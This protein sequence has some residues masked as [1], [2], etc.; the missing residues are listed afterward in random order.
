MHAWR[1][2]S[3]SVLCALC[4][5]AGAGAGDDKA[6]T[7]L[8]KLLARLEDARGNSESLRQE[9]LALRREFPGTTQAV[10]AAAALA[11]LTSPPDKLDA[12]KIPALERF[13]WQPKELVAVLHEHRGRHGAGVNAVAVSPDGKRVVSG[14]DNSLVRIWDAA[15]MRLQEVLGVS[16]VVYSTAFT[17]DGKTLAVGCADGNIQFWDVGTTPARRLSALNTSS[18]GVHSLAFTADGKKL[19]LGSGDGHIHIWEGPW[20][21]PPTEPFSSYIG[22]TQPVYVAFTP[23][24]KGLAAGSLDGE[25]KICDP[26]V[27]PIKIRTTLQAHVNGVRAVAFDPTAR[28]QPLLV[29]AGGDGKLCFWRLAASAGKPKLEATVTSKNAILSLAFTADG[30]TLA[31]GEADFTVHLMSPKTRKDRPFPKAHAGAVTALA[32][33]KGDKGL[34]LVSGSSDWTVRRWDDLFGTK[35]AQKTVTSGHLAASYAAAFAP[36]DRTLITGGQ[37][38]TLRVWDVADAIGKEKYAVPTPVHI[39][40]LAC[41]PDGKRVATGGS[42]TEGHL[43]DLSARRLSQPLKGHTHVVPTVAV[44]PDGQQIVTGSGD[45][46]VR[47]WE[48]RFGKELRRFKGY[49]TPINAVTFTPDGKQVITASGGYVVDEKGQAVIKGGQ[50]E[51][52]DCRLRLW[53]LSEESEPR[54]FDGHTMTIYTVAVAPDGAE[55]ASGGMDLTLRFWDAATGKERKKLDMKGYTYSATYSP[56]GRFFATSS[57]DAR[58]LVH[59]R[60]ADKVLHNWELRET[61]RRLAFAADSRHLAVTLETGVVYILRLAAPSDVR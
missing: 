32:F 24:G 48:P 38:D 44:S 41:L 26:T 43:W 19:A 1:L 30:K 21:K 47:I 33:A 39:Y 40:T 18:R 61:P 7:A 34:Y 4:L 57:S 14:G 53:D 25:L 11:K 13:D 54:K 45:K 55:L 10:Q 22:Q 59:D 46:S 29:S 9:L 12:S 2:I 17:P 60:A 37:D 49:T 16:Y 8:Q 5:A 20:E 51:Y 56:D 23:D 50:Y 31:Y 58:V 42:G 36:D 27:Q 28:E 15:T 3:L 35:P 6:E 52:T